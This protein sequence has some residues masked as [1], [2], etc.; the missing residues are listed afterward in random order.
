MTEKYKILKKILELI[1][2]TFDAQANKENE[3]FQLIFNS[4]LYNIRYEYYSEKP[5][6]GIIDDD[7]S[8]SLLLFTE[9]ECQKIIDNY[10]TEQLIELCI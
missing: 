10:T 5:Y 2:S 9:E 4:E 7:Y 6:V 1:D 8:F 3:E